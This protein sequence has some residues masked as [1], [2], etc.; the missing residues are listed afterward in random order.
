MQKRG[1]A[2][3]QRFLMKAPGDRFQ[4]PKCFYLV[5]EPRL[6][7]LLFILAWLSAT[8]DFDH[9]QWHLQ[10]WVQVQ[11]MWMV[12]QQQTT[13]QPSNL[14]L[15][16]H[17]RC[18]ICMWQQL[19]QVFNSMLIPSDWRP[20]K[21]I[22]ATSTTT[23]VDEQ[24]M[25]A[26]L[27]RA[28]T[29]SRMR[30]EDAIQRTRFFR[31]SLQAQCDASA[32][33]S[34][35]V[36]VWHGWSVQSFCFWSDRTSKQFCR[37]ATSACETYRT[38]EACRCWTIV[39]NAGA[40]QRLASELNSTSW[41]KRHRLHLVMVLI[42][43]TV[44]IGQRFNQGGRAGYTADV[45]AATLKT[46]PAWKGLDP[47]LC[48]P[49]SQT[50]F[51]GQEPW[52]L[53][54]RGRDQLLL[55]LW[56]A[57][58]GIWLESFNHRSYV[59]EFGTRHPHFY[60]G[61]WLDTMHLMKPK[62]KQE[63]WLKWWDLPDSPTNPLMVA[64]QDLK[65]CDTELLHVEDSQWE[66]LHWHTCCWMTFAWGQNNGSECCCR[67]MVNFQ[68]Q[69]S[70]LA[71]FLIH[72]EEWVA[73]LKDNISLHIDKEPL[74]MLFHITTSQ[75]LISRIWSLE[76]VWA[77]LRCILQGPSRLGLRECSSRPS[78]IS[79]PSH[80]RHANA[81]WDEPIQ[82]CSSS[83]S[84]WWR[85]MSKMRNVLHGWWVSLMHWHRQWWNRQ[86]S[87]RAVW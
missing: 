74:V 65:F 59:M 66:P 29:K 47:T 75:R 45:G 57:Q 36:W 42:G 58:L 18:L 78:S 21:A 1:R 69:T 62:F 22:L 38:T 4:L 44:I 3:D 54:R 5:A 34:M 73:W 84:R 39:F 87:Q 8:D 52:I 76:L 12:L 40:W 71:S 31:W 20:I 2:A 63:P 53:S 56:Q 85:A 30:A 32:A 43:T 15:T 77:W 46:P 41:V 61:R 35:V 27:Q 10:L 60:A 23:A 33:W 70:N 64:L 28:L 68:W 37:I 83:H 16:G 26:V 82:F 24:R 86:W 50:W 6:L 51:Y 79:E 19:Q 49:G 55:W 13:M 48:D 14:Q 7:L 11:L 81:K 67:W 25:V 72:C 9:V 17:Q 80:S